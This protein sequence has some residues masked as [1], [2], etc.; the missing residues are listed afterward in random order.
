MGT[1]RTSNADWQAHHL[2][3]L[4]EVVGEVHLVHLA[5]HHAWA[6]LLDRFQSF[7]NL[8]IRGTLAVIQTL[9]KT[10]QSHDGRVMLDAERFLLWNNREINFV[11]TRKN[12][13]VEHSC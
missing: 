8:R 4:G 13:S 11:E 7:Q 3:D 6:L 12:S 10:P 9:A 2:H 1:R 5:L